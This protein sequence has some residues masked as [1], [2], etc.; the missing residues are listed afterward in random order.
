M[1]GF[2]V[3]AVVFVVVLIGVIV[4]PFGGNEA[5]EDGDP[6]TAEQA[7]GQMEETDSE[8]SESEEDTNENVEDE[9]TEEE[10][11]SSESDESIA[12]EDKQ[13][14]V[15][16]SNDEGTETETQDEDEAKDEE[17]K[18][19]M[20]SEEETVASDEYIDIP[21]VSKEDNVLEVYEGKWGAIRTE[22]EGKHVATFDDTTK[23]WEEMMDS[24]YLGAGVSEDSTL[25]RVNNGGNNQTAVA[26][27]SDQTGKKTYRVYTA[28]V[29]GKGWKPMRVEVL[30]DNEYKAQYNEQDDSGEEES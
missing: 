17:E 21:S 19:E 2:S 25:W 14:D 20:E 4:W 13:K 11:A 6:D 28:W 10:S 23:D 22:Q 9:N 16:E 26:T 24:I 1:T 15:S 27:I 7:S 12:D 5:K 18:E 8:A 30:K 29:E 3:L